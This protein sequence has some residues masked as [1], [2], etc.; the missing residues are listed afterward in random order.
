MVGFVN[1]SANCITP[2]LPTAPVGPGPSS[3][4]ARAEAAGKM[5]RWNR[6]LIAIS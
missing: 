6:L 5:P 4:G 2:A 1:C 3:S